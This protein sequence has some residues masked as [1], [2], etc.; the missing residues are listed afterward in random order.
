LATLGGIEH[1]R[2]EKIRKRMENGLPL[3]ED[4]LEAATKMKPIFNTF[5]TGPTGLLGLGIGAH[6]GTGGNTAQQQQVENESGSKK[7]E[8]IYFI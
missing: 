6:S 2:K 1:L 4:T 5:G 3:I 8:R 7:G